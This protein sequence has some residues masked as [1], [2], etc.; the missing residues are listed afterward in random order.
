M[1]SE[2]VITSRTFKIECNSNINGIFENDWF[3]FTAYSTIE[4]SISISYTF[5]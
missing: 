5:G 2:Y 4:T 3:H 1:N